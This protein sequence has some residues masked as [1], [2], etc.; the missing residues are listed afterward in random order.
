MA[1]TAEQQLRAPLPPGE[2]ESGPRLC[3]GMIKVFGGVRELL[4]KGG[5]VRLWG[6]SVCEFVSLTDGGCATTPITTT[7]NTA[8]AA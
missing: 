5:C 3:F 2:W 6:H 1:A 7:T 8:G 4:E